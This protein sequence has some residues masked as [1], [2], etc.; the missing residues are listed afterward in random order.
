MSTDKIA[1]FA[2]LERHGCCS[3]ASLCQ[4]TGASNQCREILSTGVVG[5]ASFIFSFLRENGLNPLC[6][7]S[8]RD[9]QNATSNLQIRNRKR[10]TLERKGD[11]RLCGVTAFSYNENLLGSWSSIRH[12]QNA[13]RVW[14]VEDCKRSAKP[15]KAGR[16]RRGSLDRLLLCFIATASRLCAL[17]AGWSLDRLL[18]QNR[19]V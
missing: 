3:W 9:S 6:E 11:T 16:D 7:V 19:E 2:C 13:C 14:E 12:V 10:V 15:S 4:K 5:H 17:E 1:R 18:C 8:R